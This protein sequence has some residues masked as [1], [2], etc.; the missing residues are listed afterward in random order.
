MNCSKKALKRK[1][2]VSIIETM[3]AVTIIAILQVVV[4]SS[5]KSSIAKM[6]QIAV[7]ASENQMTGSIQVYSTV[8]DDQG[9]GKSILSSVENNEDKDIQELIEHNRQYFK[10]LSDSLAS[11][12][13]E[14]LTNRGGKNY[15]TLEQLRAIT[16][17]NFKV[18]ESGRVIV[19]S[20]QEK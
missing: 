13:I 2:G 3:I 16:D 7:Q 18:D 12:D 19:L 9:L 5:I 11:S 20:S 10:N 15:I 6:R 14:A 8:Y 17:G 4:L 1:K